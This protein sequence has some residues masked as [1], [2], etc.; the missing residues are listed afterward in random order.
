MCST[1][2]IPVVPIY[3]AG[4][5]IVMRVRCIANIPLV[6][7]NIIVSTKLQ[8]AIKL[9]GDWKLLQ[10]GNTSLWL[11]ESID[12]FLYLCYPIESSSY[13]YLWNWMKLEMRRTRFFFLS[14]QGQD[15]VRTSQF[16]ASSL[17]RTGHSVLLISRWN[18]RINDNKILRFVENLSILR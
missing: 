12:V 2:L 18:I 5:V 17:K 10:N 7:C 3:Q 11:H 8:A 9:D 15:L 16:S 14:P 13:S 4:I 6:I 1:V